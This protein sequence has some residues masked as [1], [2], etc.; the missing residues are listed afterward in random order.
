MS[1]AFAYIIYA[2]VFIAI[3]LAVEGLWLFGRSM[4]PGSR[5]INRRLYEIAE[6]EL[7]EMAERTGGRVYP[8]GAL[9]DLD[10]F[11][12]QVAAELRLLYSLGYYPTNDKRDGKWRA[13]RVEMRRRELSAQTRPGYR[14]AHE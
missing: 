9:R 1:G 14:A 7:R 8:V 3:V 12:A 5:E 6:A 10:R 11:Y 4:S 2:A 13:L